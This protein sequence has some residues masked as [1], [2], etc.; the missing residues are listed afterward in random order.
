MELIDPKYHEFAQSSFQ[1][2]LSGEKVL[3]AIEMERQIASG[4]K[5]T[6]EINWKILS[7]DNVVVGFWES[8][9]M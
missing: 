5:I 7:E 9:A 1:K 6:L 2:A 8:L 4:E 3:P